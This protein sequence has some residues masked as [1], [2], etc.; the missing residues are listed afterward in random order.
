V[1][2]DAAAAPAH[3]ADIGRTVE[4]FEH[5]FGRLLF[6]E[7]RVRDLEGECADLHAAFAEQFQE[8]CSDSCDSG[9]E[10]SDVENERSNVLQRKRVPAVQEEKAPQ[11]SS[12]A[13][14]YFYWD[15]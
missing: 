1:Q 15:M 5:D 7:Q 2:R 10:A 8:D 12:W 13:V 14:K 4:V 9:S 11:S 3:G 6:L